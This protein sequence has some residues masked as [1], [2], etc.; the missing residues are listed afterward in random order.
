M[1][2][3]SFAAT[4][5]LA[6][7]VFLF[8]QR[9]VPN[10]EEP[11]FS[12][13]VDLTHTVSDHDPTFD[14]AEKFSAHTVSDYGKDGYFAREISLP[15]HYATH[16]DAP[17]H[18]TRGTWAVDEIPPERLVRSL[19]VLDV[20]AK[21]QSNPDYVVDVADIAKWEADH[22]HIPPNAVVMVRTGWDQRWS[23][24]KA[25][26]NMNDKGVRQFP[27]YSLEAAEFLV[28]ARG[29]V[30]L[31]IDTLSID[32]GI[33]SDFPVHHYTSAHGVYHIEAVANLDLVP[34]LGATVVVAPT[35]LQGGSG[36]PV[37]VLALIK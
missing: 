26:R 32:P 5:G 24:P 15:E 6:L 11:L 8:A 22:G 18:F 20:S 34:A 31:G 21:A 13:V 23:S 33:S 30:G 9:H 19:A 1:R 3:K 17:V 27:G 16:V 37:R 12:H 36:A 4:C 14:D 29:A 10:S 28:Q 7:A 25:F 35:K 2:L